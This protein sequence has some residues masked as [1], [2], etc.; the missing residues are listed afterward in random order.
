V[1]LEFLGNQ[2]KLQTAS[3]AR[4]P[5]DSVAGKLYLPTVGCERLMRGA[6]KRPWLTMPLESGDSE[7]P[8]AKGF[9]FGHVQAT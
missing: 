2:R 4:R 9:P 8:L 3:L 7:V 6:N 1:Q 5:A